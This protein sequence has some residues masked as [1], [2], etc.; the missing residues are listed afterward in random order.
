MISEIDVR[1]WE[2]AERIVSEHMDVACLPGDR[3]ADWED[4]HFLIELIETQKAAAKKVPFLF[5]GWWK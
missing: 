3:G 1:D 4:Y 5:R 2:R